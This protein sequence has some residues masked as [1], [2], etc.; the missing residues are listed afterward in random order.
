MGTEIDHERTETGSQISWV[1]LPAIISN[2]YEALNPSSL[3][4]SDPWARSPFSPPILKWGSGNECHIIQWHHY[5]NRASWGPR[6]LFFHKSPTLSFFNLAPLVSTKYSLGVLLKG[7]FHT[8]PMASILSE[9]EWHLR[10]LTVRHP[11][12][13]SQSAKNEYFPHATLKVG[14]LLT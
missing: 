5:A 10:I 9:K 13:Q 3:S 14:A 12:L 6:A 11:W 8:L 2:S 7:K 4:T 1:P